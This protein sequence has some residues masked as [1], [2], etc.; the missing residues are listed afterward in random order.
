MAVELCENR[1]ARL[2]LDIDPTHLRPG[3]TASRPAMM[4][5]ADTVVHAAILSTM[6]LLFYL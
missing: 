2:R 4:L 1:H 6:G 3:G 5:L